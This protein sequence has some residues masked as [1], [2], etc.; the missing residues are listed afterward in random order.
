[1]LPF[2]KNKH[3]RQGS[4]VIVKERQPDHPEEVSSDMSQDEQKEL[5]QCVKDIL[6][7]VKSSDIRKIAEHV[8]IAHDILHHYMDNSEPEDSEDYDSQNQK[9]TRFSKEE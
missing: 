8:K 4:G 3:Q 6:E 2:L 5:E 9:A 7:A 1:M